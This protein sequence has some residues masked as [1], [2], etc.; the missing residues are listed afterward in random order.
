MSGLVA[1][2]WVDL[3]HDGSFTPGVDTKTVYTRTDI[4]GD[5]N[6]QAG[7]DT[8][9]FSAAG[10]QDENQVAWAGGLES[11]DTI[12]GQTTT[13][14]I[15]YDGGGAY[16]VLTTN[17]DGTQEQ[18]TYTDG[19]LTEAEQLDNGEGTL[20]DTHYDYNA[21]RTLKDSVDYTGQTNYT[22]F[23]DGTP[24]SVQAPGQQPQAVTDLNPGTE[25]P[26]GIK[27]PNGS[28]NSQTENT[29]GLATTQTGAGLIASKFGY[30]SQGR[31]T[32]LTTY[33]GG[34]PANY[35]DPAAATTGWE[36]DSNTGLLKSKTYADGSED[37][38]KY[39]AAGQLKTV[40]EPGMS[41]S[42]G[43]NA[44]GQQTSM[45]AIDALSGLVSSQVQAMDDQGRPVVTTSVD[46]GKLDTQTDTY[47]AL[48]QPQNETFGSAGNV[49]VARGY[50]PAA[51]IPQNGSPDA[52]ASLSIQNLPNGQSNAQTTYGYD[53]A[54]KRLQT[55]TVNGLTFTIAYVDNSAGQIASITA[56]RAG[57]TLTTTTLS[58][59]AGTNGNAS[60]LGGIAVVAGGTTLYNATIGQYNANGQI[61]S[62]TVTRTKADG[63]QSTDNLGYTY[64]L[65]PNDNTSDANSLTEVTDNGNVTE[66]YAYD[67]VGNF[68]DPALGDANSLNQ[69]ASL[70][71][72]LRGDVTNDGTY[73]YTYDA[74]DRM[75]S[76]TP[77]APQPGSFRLAYGYDSQGRR[78]WK[79]VYEWDE[80][81]S[82]WD[83]AYGRSYVYDGTQLV[84]E[85]DQDGTMLTGY[86]WGPTGQLLA[87]TDY[88]H[89]MPKTYVAVI[90]ASGNTAM[91]VDPAAG[92]VAAGY[93][94]D[95]YGNL[96]SAT[97]PAQAVC[98]ILGKGLFYDI[99][100]R[101]L[102]HA[103]QRETVAD[104]WMQRDKA[105]ELAADENLY[106]VDEGD[107]VNLSDTTGLASDD[108]QKILTPYLNDAL[109]A[110]NKD[111]RVLYNSGR[112]NLPWLLVRTAGWDAWKTSGNGVAFAY[113]EL[114]RQLTAA[115][116]TAPPAEKAVLTT[117][118]YGSYVP[119]GLAD[120]D[121]M[122]S[123]A[124]ATGVGSAGRVLY[125]ARGVVGAV[126]RPAI[127]WGTVG[128]TGGKALSV[129]SQIYAG[130]AG[131]L[132]VNDFVELGVGA[133]GSYHLAGGRNGFL[134]PRNYDWLSPNGASVEGQVTFGANRW[135]P[136]SYKQPSATYTHNQY[137]I[138]VLGRDLAQVR[139][140]PTP[141]PRVTQAFESTM[142]LSRRMGPRSKVIQ[143]HG[144]R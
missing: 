88:T 3:N 100:A 74:N 109:N 110:I 118:R 107:P 29:L 75:I 57:N 17:P 60:M 92:T 97:G 64:G 1:A 94:Y 31:L 123:Q 113:S 142:A 34:D 79:D 78:T 77:D 91:L 9:V 103:G 122:Y 106:R 7:T 131:S 6:A 51:G 69:Y 114:R 86:T 16:R 132:T 76:V 33:P 54:S 55:I 95:A 111:P 139:R 83:Y 26:T 8:Q 128:L 108:A 144:T 36:Y 45:T 134:D 21:N 87:V 117:I 59:Y 120:F 101:W 133:Y 38:Y 81:T 39:N 96:K 80:E 53:P 127:R 62:Q 135:L 105:G 18:D 73:A 4:T 121:L 10:V 50:Y 68:I 137:V 129:G 124:E 119:E 126:A 5:P 112:Y 2:T 125:G 23:Q 30:D 136:V 102:G 37:V 41:A 24:K 32:S 49:T 99:E 40:L 42:F 138:D 20:A 58:P 13:T 70:S 90:D 72:N 84:G 28:T 48:G 27:N 14:Q 116:A 67:G 43:Y 104:H 25:D 115:S 141:W 63:T 85:L 143:P 71:Y 89:A 52:L 93:T 46:N 44:A 98:S 65:G 61:Q 47:T 19:L 22:W 66:T 82:G 11:S 35:D 130:N 140:I 12:N 56:G 15:L